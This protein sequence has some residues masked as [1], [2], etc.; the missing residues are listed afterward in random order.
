[1]GDLSGS[2]ESSSSSSSSNTTN[3]TNIDRRQVVGEGAYGFAS[4]STQ[5]NI[6]TNTL[7]GG[8]ISAAF[9]G[10]KAAF[11][12]AM[13]RQGATVSGSLDSVNRAMNAV[14]AAD[15]TNGQGFNS[16]LGLA[17][18][19]FTGAGNMLSKSQDAT[20]SQIEA[21]NQS[22]TDKSGSVDQKTIMVAAGIAGAVAIAFAVGGEK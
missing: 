5:V 17:D 3:T 9:S 15:A 10:V 14:S 4:D 20:L 13:E 18:K 22:A 6:E 2:K 21:I 8:A 11:D 16:L 7:D 19:L 12:A 1:M